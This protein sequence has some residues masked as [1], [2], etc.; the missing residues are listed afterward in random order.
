V[1]TAAAINSHNTFE[2]PAVVK[3]APF[4]GASIE[5]GTLKI[6]LPAKSIVVLDPQ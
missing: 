4:T 1:L 6:V 3:P 2:Q 5:S